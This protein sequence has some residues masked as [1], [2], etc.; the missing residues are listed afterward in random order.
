MTCFK[1]SRK[2]WLLKPRSPRC[3]RQNQDYRL[4]DGQTGLETGILAIERLLVLCPAVNV[5]TTRVFIPVSDFSFPG[6]GN[7]KMSFPGIPGIPRMQGVTH[8]SSAHF[9]FIVLTLRMRSMRSCSPFVKLELPV[10]FK[11]V[12]HSLHLAELPFFFSEKMFLIFDEFSHIH[13]Q[14]TV[15][16]FCITL[17]SCRPTY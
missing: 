6:I 13:S 14:F 1:L 17:Y 5:T 11:M 2:I 7:G 12:E 9:R 16:L 10:A 8:W 15:T 4:S 3:S